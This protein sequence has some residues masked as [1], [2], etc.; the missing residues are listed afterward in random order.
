MFTTA[1]SSIPDPAPSRFHGS[2]ERFHDSRFNESRFNDSRFNDSTIP[3][4][5]VPKLCTR[6]TAGL[7][8]VNVPVLS[9]STA[10]ICPAFS[11]ATPS[12]IRIPLCAAALEPAM[13]AAGV[14]RPIA[15]GHAT[16]RT[17]AA[18]I[19]PA[20]SAPAGGCAGHK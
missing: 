10:V 2:T 7:P 8:T 12:R 14:A 19:S 1:R 13:M 5:N 9:S 18:P 16:I 20:A 3:K 4:S 11:S 15:Q 17:E 6:T